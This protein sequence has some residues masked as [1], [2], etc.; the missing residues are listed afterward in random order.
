MEYGQFFL[1]PKELGAEVDRYDRTP[2][3]VK[4][5]FEW[6][7]KEIPNR[8]KIFQEYLDSNNANVVLDYSE[9]SLSKLWSY[10][11]DITEYREI[12][13]DEL[14][15]YYPEKF[16]TDEER[17]ELKKEA[18]TIT[19]K[20][21]LVA[22]DVGAYFGEVLIRNNPTLRWD[23]FT[24]PKKF[25]DAKHPVIV[26]FTDATMDPTNIVRNCLWRNNKNELTKTYYL[27]KEKVLTTEYSKYVVEYTIEAKGKDRVFK[28]HKK[29]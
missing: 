1:P 25:M 2:E 15:E 29:K 4:N 3:M 11:V 14:K 20:T 8:M 12:R 23:Y 26:M 27:W 9:E 16:Y 22:L 24:K 10:M 18:K 19:T 28:I 17:Q 6:Y 21:Q 5:I 13:E 7:I